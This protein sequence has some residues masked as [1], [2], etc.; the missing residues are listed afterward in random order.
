[1]SHLLGGFSVLS[2]LLCLAIRLAKFNRPF[3]IPKS[4]KKTIKPWAIAGLVVLTMQIM[5][6]GW[7]SAN[8]ASHQC[9]GW[10]SL[11]VCNSGWTNQVEKMHLKDAFNVIHL[12]AEDGNYEFGEHDAEARVAI[13]AAHRIGAIIT[14]LMMIMLIYKV[15]NTRNNL[16][17][18]LGS[19]M[20]IL[21][22]AQVLLGVGNVVLGLPLLVATAHNIVG[23]FLLLSVVALNFVL[24]A[25][26]RR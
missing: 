1:M 15:K 26:K 10:D 19:L 23:A 18:D 12:N 20:I 21:L 14:I 4:L 8:Y 6:G 13:H 16:L 24:W 11:P 22:T 3:R 5:L 7:T 25:S 2:L 9:A 17:K